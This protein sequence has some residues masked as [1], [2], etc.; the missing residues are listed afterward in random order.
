MN[1]KPADRRIVAQWK[2]ADPMKAKNVMSQRRRDKTVK[3]ISEVI[4]AH[5]PQVIYLVGSYAS[6][7]P[8]ED[9]DIDFIVVSQEDER[10]YY[11]DVMNDLWHVDA[12]IDLLVYGQAEF[13]MKLKNN[14]Y[15]R[16][17]V[18]R[19]KVLYGSAVA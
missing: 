17:T 4:K 15:F 1:Y 12:S 7:Q 19:G 11:C 2:G 13:S 14:R 16:D 8:N 5:H 3:D 18:N 9:S 6:G 10:Q